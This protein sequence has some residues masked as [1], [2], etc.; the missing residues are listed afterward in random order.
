VLFRDFQQDPSEVMRDQERHGREQLPERLDHP[1]RR[2]V[3]VGSRV[4]DR[5]AHVLVE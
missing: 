4:P 3:G 5:F 2:G 1:P